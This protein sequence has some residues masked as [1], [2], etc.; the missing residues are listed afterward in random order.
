MFTFDIDTSLEINASPENIWKV[1]TDFKAYNDWNPMLRDMDIALH[2][3]ANIR[4]RVL[5]DKGTKL[6]LKANVTQLSEHRELRWRGGNAALLSGEHYFRIEPLAD[7]SCRFY[8]GE[9][10]SGLLLPLVR[11]VLKDAIVMYRRMNDAL[12][13]RVQQST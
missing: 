2:P 5:N 3:G 12:Y 10:F 11:F 6:G 9:K 8:H 13:Q 4:F 7:G 1:L